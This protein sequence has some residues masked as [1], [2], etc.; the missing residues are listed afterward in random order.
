[1][2]RTTKPVEGQPDSQETAETHDDL[3]RKQ[4][5]PKNLLDRLHKHKAGVLSL[6]V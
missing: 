5:S 6:H 2:E 4:P 1:M 3:H